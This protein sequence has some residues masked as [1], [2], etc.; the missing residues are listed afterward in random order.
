[1]PKTLPTRINEDGEVEKL[2]GHCLEYWPFDDEFFH[3]NGSGNLSSPCKACR[4]EITNESRAKRRLKE[5]D[6]VVQL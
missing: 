3:R 1:M 2:C 6:K 5:E 4:V